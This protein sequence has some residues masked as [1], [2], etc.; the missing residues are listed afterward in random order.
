MTHFRDRPGLTW[1]NRCK[2]WNYVGDASTFR[3]TANGFI[4]TKSGA[5]FDVSFGR[6]AKK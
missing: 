6:I 1:K 4:C 5:V 3:F 2:H